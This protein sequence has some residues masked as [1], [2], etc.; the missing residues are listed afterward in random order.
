MF[1]TEKQVAYCMTKPLA[2][3]K[4]EILW[5]QSWCSPKGPSSKEGVIVDD[6]CSGE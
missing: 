3:V 6:G 5:I 4:F 2:R 1:P